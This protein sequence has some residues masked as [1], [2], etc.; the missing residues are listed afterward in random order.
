MIKTV[1]HLLLL[2]AISLFLTA[3][4]SL[5]PNKYSQSVKKFT[6][7]TKAMAGRKRHA[8][9]KPNRN[10]RVRSWIKYFT[11]RDKARFQRFLKNGA[12]YKAHI[13]KILNKYR[14]PKELYFVALIE[15][16]YYLHAHSH[17]S[18]VG[19]WQFIRG[20]GKQYGLKI[21]RGMDDRRNIIK[22]T[23]AAAKYFKKLYGIF[24]SWELALSAYNMGEYGLLRR[25]RR[26]K[27][28]DYYRLA[29]RRYLPRET[30]DYV[31]KV[32]A[33]MHIYRN[34]R[35]YG[36]S[37][38]EPRNH[39]YKSIRKLRVP[40][41]TTLRTL[42][43]HSNT[44]YKKLKK[45]NPEFNY[46]RLPISRRGHQ[47]LVPTSRYKNIRRVA[48]NF[49]YRKGRASSRRSYYS[50]RAGDNLGKIANRFGLSVRAI[51]RLN[52]LT[53]SKILVNQKIKLKMA[54]V[55][56]RNRYHRVRAG[57]NLSVIASRYGLNL[58]R[59]K[60]MNGIS[61]SIIHP[62]QKLIVEL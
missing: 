58:R 17:A 33:A 11:K 3:C 44:S 53:S 13:E 40:G 59:L 54:S 24:G 31:P 43:K 38:K 1:N 62:G 20:T 45:L 23:H 22:A 42:A 29:R 46:G 35:R 41:N 49:S 37:L 48:G 28:R 26:A 51:K 4:S 30:R 34:A 6:I 55:Q 7:A 61:R 15:S 2:L 39:A 5:A 60:R 9:L 18:A 10:R 57:D 47:I 52:K 12:K 56:K 16:G 50:V 21:N 8:F 19:P 36:F 32:L 27:T 14:L 25:I